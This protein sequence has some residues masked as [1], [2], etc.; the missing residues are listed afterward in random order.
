MHWPIEPPGVQSERG[1]AYD[2]AL[3][4]L[5][6][7]GRAYPCRCSRRTIEAAL[8][9][10]GVPAQRFGERVYPGTCRPPRAAPRDPVRS[11]PTGA[12]AWR[13][14]LDPGPVDWVDRRLGAQSQD[15]AAAVGDF[16]LRR[17]DGLWAYQL[18]VVVDDAAQGITDVVRGEDLANHTARQIVL[19]RA[20]G[21]P[22]PRYLHTPLVLGAD[23]HKLS[24][25]NG[26]TPLDVAT[27]AAALDALR[28]AARDLGL[29]PIAPDAVMPS[30]WLEA[31]VPA[32]AGMMPAF[33][34]NG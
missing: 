28:A 7:V 14:R 33:A 19:Q 25:Q 30:A 31:A 15:V 6:A 5:A 34:R 11:A 18:A 10:R 32:W 26:A 23:G 9:A 1:A 17:A 21:R 8:A 12:C 4:E 3:T 29:P 16:V 20:L 24:K 27:P 2:A 13:L 22:T